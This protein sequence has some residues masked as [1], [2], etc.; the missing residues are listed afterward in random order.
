MN[1]RPGG[2]VTGITGDVRVQNRL[3]IGRPSDDEIVAGRESVGNRVMSSCIG[4]PVRRQVAGRAEDLNETEGRRSGG[5]TIQNRTADVSPD[6]VERKVHILEWHSK[7]D[8]DRSPACDWAAG[9]VDAGV[10]LINVAPLQTVLCE[11]VVPA[12]GREMDDE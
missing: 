8:V 1:G 12:S 5:R 11:R 9:A 6:S 2:D 10:E 7:D 3:I 4:K